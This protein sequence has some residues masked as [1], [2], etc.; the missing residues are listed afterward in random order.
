MANLKI[1][2][3]NGTF[4]VVLPHTGSNIPKN[5]EHLLLNEEQKNDYDLGSYE[6]F[7]Q[8]VDLNASVIYSDIHRYIVDLN[9]KRNEAIHEKDFDGNKL[10]IQK[11]N[12]KELI[13]SNYYDQFHDHINN[14]IIE[15]NNNENDTLLLYGHTY[16]V[17]GK[18]NTPDFNTKRPHFCLGTLDDTSANINYINKF[19]NSLVRLTKKYSFSFSKNFPYKGK[20]F[21]L[22]RGNSIQ[23]LQLEVREDICQ[24]KTDLVK[25][26]ISESVKELL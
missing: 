10:H 26:I 7:N 23:S 22:N 11:N 6:V 8:L 14:K 19:E 9:R 12:Q 15:L 3:P 4:L 16:N 13:L 17:I 20:S 21:Y 18:K 5:L 24:T 1:I 25:Y 2:N